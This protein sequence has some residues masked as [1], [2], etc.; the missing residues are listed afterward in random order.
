MND[1]SKLLSP[2]GNSDGNQDYS[3]LIR[4]FRQATPYI[5]AHR[6][7]TFVMMLSG[8]AVAHPNIS[9][10]IH[11]IALL[12]SLGTRIVIVH[13]LR[14]QLDAK[15][16]QQNIES[17]FVQGFRVSD[18]ATMDA[19]I[20]ASSLIRSQLET[21]LSMGLPNSPMHGAR[22]RVASA[23]VI[24]AKP[25]GIIDG[26]DLQ[27]TGLVRKIDTVAM[28]TLLDLGNVVLLS[29]LGYSPTGEAFSLS[30]KQ[31]AS[32]IAIALQVDKLIAFTDRDGISNAQGQLLRE[33]DPASA[34]NNIADQDQNSEFIR[35]AKTAIASVEGGV[36]RAHLM[37]YANDGALLQEL[38][39]VDGAGTLIQSANFEVTRQATEDDIP[40]IIDIISP[41]EKQGVLVRRDRDKLEEEI[42]YFTV[43][44]REGLIVALAALYPYDCDSGEIACIVTHPDY[45]NGTRGANLLNTLEVN[46]RAAGIQRVFVLT[47]QTAHWFIEN[48]FS[49]I[50]LDDLPEAKQSLYNYQRKSKVLSKKL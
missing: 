40:A 1:L 4:W 7:K 18:Q 50:Q 25:A 29:P 42:D 27:H 28:N 13:G 37:H 33:L 14:A 20:Q 38:Y 43:V 26:I 35:C 31:V 45:R 23:N 34:Q 44:E 47:T 3:Q 24:T 11:D 39:T 46:A 6:G 2:L 8:E 15:L 48:G 19:A 22:V 30:Y 32:E 16:E 12:N 17:Q 49:E 21:R 9:N 5:N 41:L 10:I 36:P